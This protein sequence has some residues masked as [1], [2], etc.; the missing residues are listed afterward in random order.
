[1]AYFQN[2]DTRCLF[3]SL[4]E[5]DLVLCENNRWR[6]VNSEESLF[7]SFFQVDQ[8]FDQLWVPS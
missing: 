7:T 8:D 4:E 5:D 3:P 1:M 2:C 6:K